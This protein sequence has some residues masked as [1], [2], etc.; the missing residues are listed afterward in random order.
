MANTREE[1]QQVQI[2]AQLQEKR[3]ELARQELARGEAIAARGYMTQRDLDA[4]QSAA[5]SAEQELAG[6]R[7]QIANLKRQVS[8]IQA[9]MSA[10]L[11]EKETANAENRTAAASLEQRTTDAESR[12]VQL[13]LVAIHARSG[14][15]RTA[16]A[17]M[18]NRPP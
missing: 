8:D 14:R 13:V 16:S 12:R 10:I 11:I 4:R 2:Q 18:V 15:C 7:R 6:Q 17:G 3:L 5:L 1:L 9:R